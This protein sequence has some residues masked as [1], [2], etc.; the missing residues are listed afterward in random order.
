MRV[1]SSKMAIFAYFTCHSFRTFTSKAKIIILRHV[2][3]QWLF[4]VTEIDDL[5]WPFCVKICFWLGNYELAFLAFGQN[6][7]QIWRATY[8]LSATKLQPRDPSFQQ[9][10]I[11]VDIRGGLLER[12]RQMSGVVQNGDFRFYRSL[13]LPNFHIQGHSYYIVLCSPL[14]ALH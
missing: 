12:G 3:P 9:G 6:C 2:V 11:Y 8:I 4:N 5:E 13:Y 10:M 7:S 14:V 1:G